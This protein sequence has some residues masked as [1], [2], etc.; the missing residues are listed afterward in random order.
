VDVE[1]F[2]NVV[3]S[4]E[5]VFFFERCSDGG[6]FFLYEGPFVRQGLER[7]SISARGMGCREKAIRTL[8]ALM[9]LISAGGEN[10]ISV[11]A[12]QVV[13]AHAYP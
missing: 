10:S 4:G 8:Q 12:D 6:G 9:A 13:S 5:G 1:Q 11:P 7:C 3:V 2:R